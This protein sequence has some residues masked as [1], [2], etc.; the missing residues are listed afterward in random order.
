MAARPILA[1]TAAR[2]GN[3]NEHADWET[4]HH[5]HT[6]ANAFHRKLERI[7]SL[8]KLLGSELIKS[9]HCVLVA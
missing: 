9:T 7:G 6:Y 1:T 2:F 8:S 5:V 3:S 4:A